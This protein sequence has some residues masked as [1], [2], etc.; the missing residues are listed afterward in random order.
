MRARGLNSAPSLHRGG[1]GAG[2]LLAR[3][4]PHD[5]AKEREGPVPVR[6]G[7]P[8]ESDLSRLRPRGMRQRVELRLRQRAVEHAEGRA[9]L[10][11]AAPSDPQAPRHGSAGRRDDVRD[12]L[13][14]ERRRF[15]RARGVRRGWDRVL[16]ARRQRL[17]RRLAVPKQ[18]AAPVGESA[19]AL[20]A[21]RARRAPREVPD[22]QHS[23]AQ[24]PRGA[25]LARLCRGGQ[26]FPGVFFV[27]FVGLVHARA[28][29]RTPA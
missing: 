25:H 3:R 15:G 13:S 10:R 8:E 9:G 5:G 29:A 17:R 21:F 22:D 12:E 4:R 6:P 1:R 7:V 27:L 23:R 18:P 19:A 16:A 24:E 20:A 11:A 26:S 14:E 2:E 28:F